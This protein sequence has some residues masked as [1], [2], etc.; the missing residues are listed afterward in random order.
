MKA[1]VFLM[2][3]AAAWGQASATREQSARATAE[4]EVQL[5]QPPQPAQPAQPIQS[6]MAYA[7]FGGGQPEEFTYRRGLRAMDE[8]QWDKAV[9]YFSQV[10]L[11]KHSKSDGALYW[12][13]YALNRQGKS[14]EAQAALDELRKSYASSRWLDDAKALEMEVRRSSGQPVSPERET[15]EDLKL[16]ALNSLV[17]TEPERAVP[18]LEKILAGTTGLKMKERALYVLAHSRSPQALP[19]LT[20]IARGGGNPDLQRRAV[21]YLGSYGGKEIGSTMAEI[22]SSTTD[23]EVRRAVLGSY[24]QNK[25]KERLLAALKSETSLEMRKEIVGMLGGAGAVEELWA[26]YQNETNAEM[27]LAMLRSFGSGSAEKLIELARTEKDPKL[28]AQ[29]IQSLGRVKTQQATD[30]LLALYAGE[31]DAAVRK[32]VVS[33]LYRQNN[34][35]ALVEL[36]RKETNAET[37]KEIVRHLAQ[38][39]SKEASDFLLDLLNK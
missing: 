14:T 21:D 33:G 10:A 38:M 29:A 2:V 18:I 22:Y 7:G 20:K 11:K 16:L 32:A 17:H 23:A 4:A 5:Q 36:A 24:M 9:D 15:D 8:K 25:D 13:A 31:Q 1:T 35:K 37:K 12:K 28:R 6:S 34:A 27:R 3:A 39:R 19:I 30:T 26:L